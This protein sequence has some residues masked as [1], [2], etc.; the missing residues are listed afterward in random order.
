MAG[1]WDWP[2]DPLLP[3]TQIATPID[4]SNPETD[5]PP[6]NAAEGLTRRQSLIM[7]T[8]G[9]AHQLHDGGSGTVR[10]GQ[11]ADLMVLDRDITRV[12]VKDVRAIGVQYTLIS[13]RVVHDARAQ[14]GRARAE[15]AQHM[16]V[17]GAGRTPGD[18]CC[19]GH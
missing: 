10:P 4:R 3:F 12:P 8:A 17:L 11:R 2:V 16:S 19:R 14:T 15:A 1:G 18:S 7:H 5:E 13:G 9:A 6:L